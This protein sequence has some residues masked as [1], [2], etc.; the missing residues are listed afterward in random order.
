MFLH[1]REMSD[2]KN[3]RIKTIREYGQKSWERVVVEKT[4]LGRGG[5]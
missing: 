5:R 3:I 4:I 2:L 1:I